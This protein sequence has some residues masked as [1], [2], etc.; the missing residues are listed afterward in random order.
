MYPD[1]LIGHTAGPLAAS[2]GAL[3]RHS[4][5]CD[6]SPADHAAAAFCACTHS[7]TFAAML[8]ILYDDSVRLM[9]FPERMDVKQDE[10][11]AHK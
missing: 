2:F 8:K 9:Q 4:C 1:D 5:A 6:H 11:C 3:L 7:C 10:T